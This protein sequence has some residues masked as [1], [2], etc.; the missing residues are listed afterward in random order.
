VNLGRPPSDAKRE[1]ILRAALK[2]FRETGFHAT[3]MDAIAEEANVSKRTVYNHFPSKD[4]L[5]DTVTDRL[6]MLLVP[7]GEASPAAALP[8]EDRLEQ[9]ALRRL[10]VLLQPDLV[11]LLKTVMSE[12][13]ASPELQRA[14]V[15]GREL[16]HGQLGL[17]ALLAE[18][19]HMG[20][21]KIEQLDLA[22]GQFWGLTL[23]PLFWPMLLGLRTPPDEEE[24]ALVVSEAVVT[25][26]SRY[27]T[28]RRRK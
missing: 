27:G 7:L 20:R 10:E 16:T 3:S 12:S 19:V 4:I 2:A 11:A 25:F 24:R 17:R 14:F 13:L 6:W 28:G 26:V 18:E 8:V 5:F 23:N 1:A 21:L 22:G 9:L 15:G